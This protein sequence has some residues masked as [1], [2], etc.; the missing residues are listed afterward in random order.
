MRAFSYTWS[1]PVTWGSWRSHN[2]IRRSQNPHATPY[3]H[4]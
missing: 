3:T 4:T 1:L 2:S